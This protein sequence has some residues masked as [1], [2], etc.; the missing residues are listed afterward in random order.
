M[1]ADNERNKKHE[2][3]VRQSPCQ[4]P[5]HGGSYMDKGTSYIRIGLL[6][7]IVTED[8]LASAPYS[9]PLSFVCS[10]MSDVQ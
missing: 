1:C 2:I 7:C 5:S 4:A 10:C 6:P 8:C 9:M 3:E